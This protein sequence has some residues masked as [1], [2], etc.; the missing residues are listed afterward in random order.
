[1]FIAFIKRKTNT[2]IK[3]DKIITSDQIYQIISEVQLEGKRLRFNVSNNDIFIIINIIKDSGLK[4]TRID[5]KGFVQIELL[6]TFKIE[7]QAEIIDEMGE[8]LL[9]DDEMVEFGQLF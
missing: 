2:K 6:P 1:M 7:D 5:C 4:F 8:D 3:T 9:F